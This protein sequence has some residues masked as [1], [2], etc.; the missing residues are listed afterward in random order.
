MNY[1][2]EFVVDNSFGVIE[3]E[4]AKWH[5]LS[6]ND[7]FMAGAVVGAVV[8]AIARVYVYVMASG[9]QG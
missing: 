3:R 1:T 9:G 2:E 4:R 5:M 8:M 6:F 7:G